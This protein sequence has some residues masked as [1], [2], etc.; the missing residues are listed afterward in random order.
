M[1]RQ[2]VDHDRPRAQGMSLADLLR[3]ASVVL[4]DF[5]GPTC[6]LFASYPANIIADELRA[7]VA[8]HGHA[9]SATGPDSLLREVA[10]LGD[11]TLTRTVADAVRD[12]EIV[13]AAS[14]RRTPGIDELLRAV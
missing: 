2:R 3:P 11:P 6:D 1:V 7:L 14:A 4:L 10:E 9:V 13:A 5:D 12:A 8:A